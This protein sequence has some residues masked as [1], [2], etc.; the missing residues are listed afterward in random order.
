MCDLVINSS[1]LTF[2]ES[3]KTPKVGGQEDI[4]GILEVHAMLPW[5]RDSHFPDFISVD[6]FA[7]L[8]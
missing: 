6:I 4:S 2:V 1:S 3:D 5:E 7:T 8:S